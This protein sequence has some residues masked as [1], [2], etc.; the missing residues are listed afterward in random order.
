[1]AL[2]AFEVMIGVVVKIK[3]RLVNDRVKKIT[4]KKK[5][6][7]GVLRSLNFGTYMINYLLVDTSK[8]VVPENRT[9]ILKIMFLI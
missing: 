3:D 7:R 8:N 5:R 6:S 9:L 4:L 2:F 1:M